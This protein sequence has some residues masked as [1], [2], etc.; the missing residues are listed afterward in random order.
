MHK[1]VMSNAQ[2]PLYWSLTQCRDKTF[3]GGSRF[4]RTNNT[5]QKSF[6]LGQHLVCR[7][8]H[9]LK[10]D[11]EKTLIYPWFR[12]VHIRIKRNPPAHQFCRHIL[13]N[14]R[15]ASRTAS[16]NGTQH[17]SSLWQRPQMQDELVTAWPAQQR[18]ISTKEPLPQGK[19]RILAAI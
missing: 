7:L 18:I 17:V 3:A 8:T 13:R 6:N 14:W 12:T 4:I 5:K 15:N 9:E 2:T 1:K 19:L 10:C 16:R 11:F